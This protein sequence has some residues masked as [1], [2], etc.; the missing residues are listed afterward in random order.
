MQIDKQKLVTVGGALLVVL[1]LILG[2]FIFSNEDSVGVRGTGE[3]GVEQGD[4]FNPPN[5]VDVPVVTVPL[6]AD[7]VGVRPTLFAEANPSDANAGV[8]SDTHSVDDSGRLEIASAKFVDGNGPKDLIWSLTT[9]DGEIECK[10]CAYLVTRLRTLIAEVLDTPVGGKVKSIVGWEPS[11]SNP[12]DFS[13][14]GEQVEFVFANDRDGNFAAQA[15]S[16]W[17][18]NCDET[19]RASDLSFSDVVWN[20]LLWSS[21][22]CGQDMATVVPNVLYAGFESGKS[23]EAD[24]DAGIDRVIVASPLHRPFFEERDGLQVMVAW[25]VTGCGTQNASGN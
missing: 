2:F 20:N 8:V 3:E 10:N 6:G 19:C 23:A 21:R 24:R 9:D 15:L 17:L 4:L 13:G 7:G 25:Q 22:G 18:L 14:Y 16:N 12:G 5:A 1:A 11:R